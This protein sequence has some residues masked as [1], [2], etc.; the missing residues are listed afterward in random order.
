MRPSRGLRAESGQTPPGR[1]A[2]RAVV[3]RPVDPRFEERR[4]P[5]R[6][7]PEPEGADRSPGRWAALD[8]LRGLTVL[9]MIP[10]NAA[11]EFT[12]VPTWFKHAPGAGLTVADLIVPAFLSA[13]GVSSSFSLRRRGSRPGSRHGGGARARR[14]ENLDPALTGPAMAR[15]HLFF[16]VELIF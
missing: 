1:P 5:A 8:N 4:E 14:A 7:G 2:S 11:K 10:I 6:C 3:V 16:L 15:K 9:L 12:A 13:L